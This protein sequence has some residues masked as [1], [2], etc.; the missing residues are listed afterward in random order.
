MRSFLTACAFVA[1]L[2]GWLAASPLH[3]QSLD[4]LIEQALDKHDRILKARADVDK[5]RQEALEALGD[6]YPELDTTATYGYQGIMNPHD[7]NTRLPIS[8]LDLKL[9]QKL[10]DFGTANAS[11][12]A[13]RLD[14]EEARLKLIK[15]QAK[16]IREAAGIY[17]GVE[18]SNAFLRFSH[19]LVEAVREKIKF[20]RNKYAIESAPDSAPETVP[21]PNTIENVEIPS[22]FT[23]KSDDTDKFSLENDGFDSE[24]SDSFSLSTNDSPDSV[25][26]WDELT[27]ARKKEAQDELRVAEFVHGFRTFF[28]F[29]PTP[30][31]LRPAPLLLNNM[32]ASI[33]EAVSL[34]LK[35][36]VDIALAKLAEVQARKGVEQTKSEE[37]LPTV[38]GVLE[39]K[40]K[41]NIDG[42]TDL[43]VDTVA[44]VELSWTINLGMTAVNTLKAAESDVSST[45]YDLADTR[46]EIEEKVRDAWHKIETN[47]RVMEITQEQ[48]AIREYLLQQAE[49]KAGAHGTSGTAG[50]S[51]TSLDI[52][53]FK[54]QIYEA[55][56]DYVKAS[57]DVHIATYKL[58]ELIGQ[59]NENIFLKEDTYFIAPNIPPE[60]TA[61][62]LAKPARVPAVTLPAGEIPPSLPMGST[63]KGGMSGAPQSGKP[64]VIEI[65]PGPAS[66]PQDGHI[67]AAAKKP[68]ED[69]FN[70][71]RD[72]FRNQFKAQKNPVPP[73]QAN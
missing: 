33:D 31:N 32:P 55:N 67:S 8:E 58:L 46:L 28:G 25:K 53:N 11:I 41:N 22:E 43:K 57:Y 48:I 2:C 3:A 26:I 34:A 27:K 68:D 19:L 62:E 1:G 35:S 15:V 50:Q 7:T 6:W 9:T 30:D 73:N 61:L 72:V 21:R 24:V 47:R 13:A 23:P 45:A 38:D 10:W 63:P 59:L 69:F 16:L 71:V 40:W 54:K 66:D 14:L 4:Q 29:T 12:A 49:E 17:V 18:G 44:K 60:V 5:A 64:L 36:N 20:Q 56:R 70:A 52:I 39:R 65:P 37:F 42:T 51:S